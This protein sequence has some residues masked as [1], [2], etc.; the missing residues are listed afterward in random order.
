MR[1]PLFLG[2]VLV[3]LLAI[4]SLGVSANKWCYQESPD[5]A[6]A[7]SGT[8][9]GSDNGWIELLPNPHWGYT[10]EM[11]FDGNWGT[12]SYYMTENY[13][14]AI[15]EKPIDAFNTSV[16]RFGYSYTTNYTS[17]QENI[18]I[19]E[20]CWN[21]NGSFIRFA[22][23][24]SA[25]N[26]GVACWNGTAYEQLL[27]RYNANPCED[28]MLWDLPCS[29]NW[30]C[31]EYGECQQN[32][33]QYC[34]Q[35][36]DLNVCGDEYTGDFSEFDPLICGECFPDWM[37][38][39]WGAECV[40]GYYPCNATLDLNSCGEPYEGNYSEFQGVSCEEQQITGY[41]AQY[42]VGDIPELT[43]DTI[44]TGIAETIKL[45]GLIGIVIAVCC[46]GFLWI[47]RK[48]KR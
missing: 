34:N 14:S 40:E 9:G 21:G 31:S 44:G 47:E 12:C 4:L 37:C 3:C 28:A 48:K 29:P 19:P 41:V 5:V 22:F 30:N 6:V 18:T 13:Q 24:T 36:T 46:A 8:S 39:E 43:I 10:F 35:T 2:A 17:V 32:G 23:G 27:L 16:W 42:G 26:M 38:D 7:C 20:S 25:S 15:Y 11:L 45:A 1:F 33:R